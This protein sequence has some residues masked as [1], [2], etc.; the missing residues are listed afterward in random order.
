MAV[1]MQRGTR[2]TMTVLPVV[3]AVCRCLGHAEGGERHQSFFAEEAIRLEGLQ[4][5]DLYHLPHRAY[6]IGVWS[7]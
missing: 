1:R 7:V 2:H 5:L 6:A 3:S 4:R